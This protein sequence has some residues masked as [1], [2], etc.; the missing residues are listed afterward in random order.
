VSG[1]SKSNGGSMT[2]HLFSLRG[3]RLVASAPEDVGPDLPVPNPIDP[4]QVV[5]GDPVIANPLDFAVVAILD[6]FP[7]DMGDSAVDA[8]AHVLLAVKHRQVGC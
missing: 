6:G 1:D 5:V 2:G 3:A 4:A 7:I 8:V